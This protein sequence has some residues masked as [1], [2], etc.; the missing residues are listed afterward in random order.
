MNK[1][2]IK[3]WLMATACVG[4][5]T[6]V[7]GCKEDDFPDNAIPTATPETPT[8]YSEQV[9]WPSNLSRVSVH[10]PSV[11]Y[12]PSSWSYFIFG[13]HR[14]VAK[15]PNMMTWSTVEVPWAAGGNTGVGN[16]VAFT[17]P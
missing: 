16:D 13:S 8:E 10:D 15:S 11:V 5:L 3:Y 17:N 2:N 14:A 7:T 4:L 12:D 9:L 6:T 1:Q